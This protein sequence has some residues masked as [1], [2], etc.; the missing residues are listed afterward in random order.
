MS[1]PVEVTDEEALAAIVREARV[2][3]VIGMVDETK[4]HRP[5]LEIPR[6]CI[7]RGMQVI[8]VNPKIKASLGLTAYPDLASVPERFD[9]VNVFRRSD[10]VPPHADEVLALPPERRPR[11]FW[12]QTG[13]R[14]D[15]AAAKLAAAGIAV[16]MDHCLGVYAAKYRK[17]V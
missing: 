9:V 8:P 2:V 17:R 12:M 1:T 14:N 7:Q 4:S 11:V 16:V 10:D 3:A 6:I 15:A 13:I 5:A